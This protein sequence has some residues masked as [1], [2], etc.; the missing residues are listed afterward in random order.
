VWLNVALSELT[1][2]SSIALFDNAA[3]RSSVLPA[4]KLTL[5][6]LQAQDWYA[7]RS[8][9]SSSDGVDEQWSQLQNA[10]ANAS[11]VAQA[12]AAGPYD[13]FELR[14]KLEVQ[15]LLAALEL[16]P[17]LVTTAA[18]LTALLHQQRQ[19][20]TAVDAG[21]VVRNLSNSNAA[22]M[23]ALDSSSSR[24]RSSGSSSSSSGKVL[25]HHAKVLEQLGMSA[26]DPCRYMN[27]AG[28]QRVQAFFDAMLQASDVMLTSVF[29]AAALCLEL[30][31]AG[32]PLRNT[33]GPAAVTGPN[34]PYVT[35]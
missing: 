1:V 25:P 16:H 11:N 14:T 29:K 5:L 27:A 32:S 8:S 7:T 3:A 18:W 21:S 4:V 22:A 19:G 6:M 33:H 20:R 15:Q 30:S 2:A 23:Y 24:N 26:A 31:C 9:S 10:L 34:Q 13:S 17:L 35:C 12:I 28:S